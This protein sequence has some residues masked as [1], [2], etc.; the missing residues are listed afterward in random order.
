MQSAF[1]DVQT[2]DM[3]KLNVPEA[4]RHVVILKPSDTTIELAEEIAERADRIYCGG[5]DSH[6]DNMVLVYKCGQEKSNNLYY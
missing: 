1:A 5:V 4:E 3:V 6:I 2:A